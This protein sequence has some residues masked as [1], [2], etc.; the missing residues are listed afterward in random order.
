MKIL[1][2]YPEFPYPLT[3]GLLRGF[4]LVR[5]LSHSHAITFLSLTADDNIS[6]ERIQALEPYAERIEIF[7]KRCSPPP[8]WV[9]VFSRTPS[10]GWRLRESWNTASAVKRMKSRVQALLQQEAFDVVLFSG[11]EAIPLLES[12]EIPIVVDCGDTNCTRILQQMV[13]ADLLL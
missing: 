1:W 12:L 2:I 10:L 6:P 3:S 8:T 5:L 11:R 9:R 13:Q 7:S 4:H